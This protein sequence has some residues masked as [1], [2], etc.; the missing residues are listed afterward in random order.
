M[1][2]Y[3]SVDM[4]GIAGTFDWR[5]EETDRT[6]VRKC[7]TQ[8]LEW[9]LEGIKSSVV[10]AEIQEIVIADSHSKGDNLFYDLSALDDR[11]YLISGAPR[12]QYMMP[13][14]D[15]SYDC[16]FFIGYHSGI[17]VERGTMDH[18]YTSCFHKIWI[19][20]KPMSEA[21][22]NAAYAGYCDVP[23]GLVIGDAMLEAGVKALDALP[24]VE[25]VTTKYGLSRFAAKQ[26]PVKNVKEETISTVQKVLAT[27]LSKLPLYRLDGP[28]KLTIEYQTTVMAD[29][30]A[31]VPGV[32]RLDGRTIEFVHEDYRV[33]FNAIMALAMLAVTV[34]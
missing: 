22:I 17:G 33:V 30:G 3:I 31:L 11:V 15:S 32:K 12:P 21:L 16:A 29:V 18:T 13:A 14:L 10:N 27:D 4:E 7:M 34:K 25:F 20:G 26:R 6:M 28:V 1:K 8:Q 9:M 23:V 2:L 5:Q 19:N 24:W